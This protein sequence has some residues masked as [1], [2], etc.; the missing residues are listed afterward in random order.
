MTDTD[1]S[2]PAPAPPVR[3]Q[4]RWPR[5]IAGLVLGV[6]LLGGAFYAWLGTETA[7][8]TV[9]DRVVA[10]SEGRLTIEG[11]QGSLL[12]LVRVERLAWNGDDVDVEARELAMAWSPFDLISRR[13]SVSGLGAK[14]LAITIRES[15]DTKTG[16]PATLALPL[17]VA[18]RNVGVQS[19]TWATPKGSGALTGITFGYAGGATAHALTNM[20]FVTPDGTL[21]GGV[22]IGANA[23]FALRGEIEFAG[24]GEWQGLRA[25]AKAAGPLE[26]LDL[27][28]TGTFRE[29]KIAARLVAT[30]FAAVPIVAA[31]IDASAVDVSQWDASW[32]ATNLSLKLV[33]R[34]AGAGFAGT[35]DARNADA[36][37]LDRSRIPAQSLTAQFAWLDNTLTL[38]DAVVNIAGGGV[39]SGNI[40]IPTRGGASTF[41]LQLRNVDLARIQSTLLVTRLSG[42]L[43]ADVT[44]ARQSVRGDLREDARALAFAAVVE[45][46]RVR[47]DSFRASAAGG[48]LAGQGTVSLDGARAFSVNA[49]ARN[50]DPSRFAD[51][52]GSV[53]KGTI[54]AS[55]T[56]APTWDVM[57]K[58]ALDAG[59]QIADTK[60]SGTA[61]G[62]FTAQ[63]AVDVDANVQ[64][65][66]ATIVLKGAFGTAGDKLNFSLDAPRVADLRP[67]LV[68]VT[69][70]WPEGLAGSLKMSGV[71][72]GTPRNP[73]LTVN[74]Q[75]KALQWGT[76]IRA[77]TLEIIGSVAPGSETTAAFDSRA[78][79]IAVTGTGLG[80]PQGELRST[81]IKVIGTLA[82]HEG[83]IAA[84][85]DG[86]AIGA[87]FAGGLEDR[88]AVGSTRDLAWSGTVSRL[89]NT[90]SVPLTL[91]A[92]AT[93]SISRDRVAIGTAR[94]AI[95][96]GRAD[97]ERFV[98]DTGRIDTMGSFTGVPVTALARLA[99][100]TFPLVS[101]LVIG[102]DWALTAAPK[103]NGRLNVKRESGDWYAAE[104]TTLDA[105][106]LA[107]GISAFDVAARFVDDALDASARFRSSRAGTAD[108]TLKIAAGAA[109]GQFSS[110]AAMQGTLQADMATLRPLQPWLGTSAVLDGRAHADIDARGTLAKPIFTGTLTG[111]ALSVAVPQYGVALKDGRLRAR[112]ADRS[113]VLDEL[114][115]QGGEGRF[116]AEGT[117]AHARNEAAEP[118]ANRA[119]VEVRW[120]AEKFT[121]VNRPDL[122]IVSDGNGTLALKDHRLA[123]TGKLD[124]VEGA[125]VYAPTVAGRL[126]SDV[127]IV[128]RPRATP[129]SGGMGDVPL[130]LNLDVG[131]GSNFRFRGDGLET[132]LEGRVQVTNNAAGVLFANGT[133]RAVEGTYYVFGQRLVIDRGNLI[134]NGRADNPGLDVV[135]LRKNL[136]V[137]AGVEVQGTVRVPRVRLVSNPPVPDGEK[138]SWLITGQGLARASGADL[139]AL[140]AASASLLTGGQR[141]LTAQIANRLGLDD[142]SFRESGASATGGTSGQVVALGKRISDR[143]T[144]VYEQGLTV[145]TNALRI[146]YAL[147][148]TLTLRAEAGTISSVGIFFRRVYQ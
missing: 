59:S 49:R 57:A 22:T 3:R 139:A 132:R 136:A 109:P 37:P 96:D 40:T 51:V 32:P 68:R 107:L 142:I 9:L 17:E 25:A 131:F 53:L 92:P 26:R 71:L 143:L 21:T 5:V 39:A 98:I 134:F 34:P 2:T 112:L 146:E 147:S 135:A 130:S 27:D 138:L 18:I 103:L 148:Q 94:I 117:V 19:L 63:R 104:S 70:D 125:V 24:E 122:R 38:T 77:A 80:V 85:G 120:R 48:E 129:D 64:A 65:S 10:A 4:R 12:S 137:E 29:A 89:T 140:S 45:G 78:L 6:L 23:P 82:R 74:A 106:E 145:A 72:A 11:A 46:K 83:S 128:G 123:L 84:T 113:I 69:P 108:A 114:S 13:F 56:L 61:R 20:R 15:A 110:T 127:V 58:V 144:I 126:S 73:G 102:G 124:I 47:I 118:V 28:A 81:Q 41:A 33:A 91:A 42:T 99:G 43:N 50:F 133:I 121:V 76:A 105:A 54:E 116:V 86:F 16:L 79:Q 60:L 36:G 1:I 141:P 14:H 31:D 90:G 95:A 66:S 7:L 30:P 88:K 93:L 119:N 75:G 8:R 87:G 101:T 111:D 55:G 100:T 35:I 44:G 62:R 97:I 67:M 115:L 52:P